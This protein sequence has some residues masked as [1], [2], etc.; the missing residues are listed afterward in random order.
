[1]ISE[2]C[3]LWLRGHKSMQ[4]AYR[5]VSSACEASPAFLA[6]RRPSAC[7]ARLLCIEARL[8]LL[9]S[10]G[11]QLHV[12]A[13]WGWRDLLGLWRSYLCSACSCALGKLMPGVCFSRQ[14]CCFAQGCTRWRV[15]CP[16][17]RRQAFPAVALALVHQF[18][19]LLPLGPLALAWWLLSDCC[20]AACSADLCCLL[21]VE[22]PILLLCSVWLTDFCT[23]THA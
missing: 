12:E 9:W 15:S 21:P 1:M 11:A 8:A 20:S 2:G 10:P 18:Q 22:M 17:L 7:P 13:L 14:P 3:A 19:E 23:N 5:A 16:L 4:S 6:P